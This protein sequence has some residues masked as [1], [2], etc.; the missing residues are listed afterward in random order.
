MRSD[1]VQAVGG[2]P[3]EIVAAVDADED[4]ALAAVEVSR[5]DAGAFQGLPG[6]VE[7]KPLLGVDGERLT[8][9]DAEEGRIE[10]VGV[11]NKPAGLGSLAIKSAEIPAAVVVGA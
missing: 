1:R 5:V 6:H 10:A 4:A 7:Q 2:Q 11:I 8:R 3:G 9:A